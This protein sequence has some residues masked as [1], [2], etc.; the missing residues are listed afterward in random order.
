ML[1]EKRFLQEQKKPDPMPDPNSAALIGAGIGMRTCDRL[2]ETIDACQELECFAY[3]ASH[4]LKGPLNRLESYSHLLEK[5]YGKHLDGDG[6]F[7]LR[8]IRQDVQRLT[9]LVDE[10]LNYTKLSQQELHLQPVDVQEIMRAILFEHALDIREHGAEIILDLDQVTVLADA[11]C[12][13]R[14]I[15][16]L[17]D[18]ALKYS[19]QSARPNIHINGG[20]VGRRYRL[21]V[22]DNGIG[23]NMQSHD[24]IFEIFRRLHAYSE[25]PG[26]GVGLALARRAIDRMGGKI[27]A[28]STPGQGATFFVELEMVPGG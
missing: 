22:R 17:L 13:S 25:I 27:W 20:I 28:Q 5:K 24:R 7:F 8:Y 4:D 15:S 19:S 1:T 6:A 18:N 9:Q 26:H 3:A 10:L 11:R 16:N 12:L 2:A 14:A 21:S 23:F